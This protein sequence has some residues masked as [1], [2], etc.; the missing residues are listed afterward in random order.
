MFAMKFILACL[1]L[2]GALTW[3]SPGGNL[4][5]FGQSKYVCDFLGG[6]VIDIQQE[7]RI[8]PAT[9]PAVSTASGVF[10]VPWIKAPDADLS[11]PENRHGL[12]QW[13]GI[14]GG[15]CQE[16]DWRP[17]LQAGTFV[18][19]DANGT[20][21]ADAFVEWFPAGARILSKEN[22]TVSPGDQM[23]V[24]VDVR[25][26]ITGHVYMKNL[27]TGQEYEED[28]T[29]PSPEEPQ[30]QICLGYGT[31]LFF[32]EWMIADDRADVPI[33]NNV[34]FAGIGAWSRQGEYFD[35]GTGTQ[36]YWNM[37]DAN[38]LIAIPKELDEKRF[39]VY[40]PEGS[41]WIPPAI[42]NK[43]MPIP[44]IQPAIPGYA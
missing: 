24:V 39:V 6:A 20:S 31:A 1:W 19:L 2:L 22:M 10:N 14:L 41:T 8:E 25:T 15:A 33:F 35:F 13:V 12:G 16:Q 27:N 32:Q 36:D 18:W 40:S 9:S 30:F 5:P 3:A 4:H 34:T 44:I 38:R 43:G 37:T 21:T 17:F 7:N 11:V 42:R 28:I 23:Q 26:R 29:S